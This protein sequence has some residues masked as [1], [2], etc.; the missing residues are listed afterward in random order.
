MSGTIESSL[1]SV[2]TYLR[3]FRRLE[4]QDGKSLSLSLEITRSTSNKPHAPEAAIPSETQLNFDISGPNAS[5]KDFPVPSRGKMAQT[6]SEKRPIA[7]P[8][9]LEPLSIRMKVDTKVRRSE[10]SADGPP[11]KKV[12]LGHSTNKEMPERLGFGIRDYQTTTVTRAE[13]MNMKHR[14][15]NNT[16]IDMEIEENENEMQRLREKMRA[17]ELRRKELQQRKDRIQERSAIAS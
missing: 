4:G 5:S 14:E 9:T 13:T 15:R 16:T 8:E 11:P 2:L 6:S 1:H 12:K 3:R 10:G 17:L 7:A